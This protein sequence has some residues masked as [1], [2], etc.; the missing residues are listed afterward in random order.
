MSANRLDRLLR[1]LIAVCKCQVPG[2]SKYLSSFS[3][4]ERCQNL[5]LRDFLIKPVQRMC[6]YP[7]F[8]KEM[9]KYSDKAHPDFRYIKVAGDELSSL[10]G[11]IETSMTEVSSSRCAALCSRF[12]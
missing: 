1:R 11:E 12:S 9:L 2:F 6:K 10:T 8:L 4:H 5:K 7:L 3:S